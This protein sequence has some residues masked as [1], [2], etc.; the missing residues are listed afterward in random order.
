ME[1]NITVIGSTGMIGI[2]VTQELVKAGFNVTAL[3]RNP[4]KAKSIFPTG[5]TFVKGDLDNKSSI[6][7]ALK[8][9]EG[10]YINISTRAEDNEHQFNPEM[11]GLDNILEI[12][13][14]APNLQQIA[15]LSSFLARNYQGD[16]WV[17]KAK[18]SSIDRVKNSGIPY[19]VFYPSN[20]MENFASEGMK[21]GNKVNY[22]KASINNKAWWI[23][24]E[25]FGKIV[26]NAFKIEKSLNKEYPVQGPE[27]LTMQEAA[28]KFVNGFTKEKLSVGG[29]P[30]W[31]MKFMGF[32]MPSMK[33]VAN[34]MNVML[35]NIE[36]LEAEN[37]NQEL[38]KPIITIT[39]FAKKL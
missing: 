32:F 23:A 34:L 39:E 3:V 28:Q 22:I 9:A 27:A 8:Y 2:P 1:K 4:D 19:T 33:F 15:Y 31:I 10:L 7:E 29:F 13:K 26:A 24:G 37:T 5:V 36:T 14:Q 17:F 18:K 11:Q 6:A 16:W 35:N 20:F 12:A 25:D 30:L 21:R 38:W